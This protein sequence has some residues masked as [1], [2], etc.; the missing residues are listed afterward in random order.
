MLIWYIGTVEVI[1][2]NGKHLRRRRRRDSS[3]REPPSHARIAQMCCIFNLCYLIKTVMIQ[4][5]QR[6]H[7]MCSSRVWCHGQ[8]QLWMYTRRLHSYRC[9]W[10]HNLCVSFAEYLLRFA[11]KNARN[12]AKE[13][14]IDAFTHHFDNMTE[15]FTCARMRARHITFALGE[16]LLSTLI[17]EALCQFRFDVQA[18]FMQMRLLITK[19]MYTRR[20]ALSRLNAVQWMCARSS[21]LTV[22][23]LCFSYGWAH[24]VHGDNAASTS[25]TPPHY[26]RRN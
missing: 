16:H 9:V 11:M 12:S 4:L 13:K 3:E 6:P 8:R 25:T 7:Y 18:P 17:S 15:K 24:C 22:D 23:T 5:W 2:A 1:S 21:R 10:V 20:T 26:I 19:S 14:R